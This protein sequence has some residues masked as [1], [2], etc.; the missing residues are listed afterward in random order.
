[1]GANA[2]TQA[3]EIV[4]N[5]ERI[6]AIELMNAAQALSLRTSETSPFLMQFLASYR[7]EVAFTE[8]DKP[9]YRDI[10]KTITYMRSLNF[11]NDVLF[12]RFKA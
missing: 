8:S 3:F 9:L 11:D 4:E 12:E 6:L 7:K 2:A 10:Q 5:V 1:M